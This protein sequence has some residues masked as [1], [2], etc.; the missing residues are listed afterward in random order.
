MIRCLAWTLLFTWA[1]CLSAQ[2]NAT[3][4]SP[5]TAPRLRLDDKKA[6]AVAFIEEQMKCHSIPGIA[7]SVVFKNETI[8]ARGF[9]TKAHGHA[10]VAV[11]ADTMF[12]IGSFTKT[13]IALAIA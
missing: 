1:F 2:S 12:Q 3:K 6:K 7:L 9:G 13:F 11:T 10:D 4:A 8:P 5:P